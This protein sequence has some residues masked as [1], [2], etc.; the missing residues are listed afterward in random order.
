MTPTSLPQHLLGATCA[1]EFG[2][3]LKQSFGTCCRHLH[4]EVYRNL[5]PSAFTSV[6][7]RA[8]KTLHPQM[9][10]PEGFTLEPVDVIVP[11]TPE[12]A[13]G[14]H[15]GAGPLT[16]EQ[17]NFMPTTVATEQDQAQKIPGYMRCPTLGF[18]GMLYSIM[19][20]IGYISW[21]VHEGHDSTVDLGTFFVYKLSPQTAEL[22]QKVYEKRITVFKRGQ[23]LQ[24]DKECTWNLTPTQRASGIS[25]SSQGTPVRELQFGQGLHHPSAHHHPH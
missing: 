21:L 9:M 16:V 19:D 22:I 8:Y 20:C 25:T 3:C 18:V 6:A 13:S 10:V 23:V 2:T 11:A 12:G 17:Y 4:F 24:L 14:L 7:H 15:H 5:R 1:C